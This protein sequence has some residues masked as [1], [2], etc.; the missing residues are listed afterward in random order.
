MNFRTTYILLAVVVAALGFLAWFVFFGPTDK[1][2]ASTEGFVLKAMKAAKIE[3]AQVTAVEIEKAGSDKIVL[4]R[5]DKRWTMAAPAKARVDS[6]AVDDIVAGLL[7][8]K[9]DKS[10]QVADNLGTHGLAEPGVKVTI[11]AGDI[12]ETLNLGNVTTGGERAVVYVTTSDRPNKAQAARRND[13][14]PLF[15]AGA[16][17]TTAAEFVRGVADFR[18]LK[19]VGDGLDSPPN[20]VRGVVVRTDKDKLALTRDLGGRWKFREPADYGDAAEAGAEAFGPK[21]AAGISS[22]GELLNTIVAIQPANR[23]A[24]KPADDLSKFGLAPAQNPLQVD[25][26]RIDGVK[27]TMFIGTVT[28][29]GKETHYA[30]NELDGVV[31]VVPAE[32]VAKLRAALA[33]KGLLRD[34]TVLKLSPARVVAVEIDSAGDKIELHRTAGGWQAFDAEGKARL[35]KSQMVNELLARLAAPQLAASFPPPGVPDERSG[36]A[37]PRIEVRLYEKTLPD[38]KADAATKPK[39]DPASVVKL[40]VGADDVGDVAYARRVA[41]D[42]KSD[43]FLPGEVVQLLARGRL[44]YLDAAMKTFAPDS[45]LKLTFTAGKETVELERPD[46]GKPTAQA[47]WKINSPDRMKGRGADPLKVADL[48][49]QLSFLR[50]IRVAADRVTPDVLNRLEVNPMSPRGKAVVALKGGGDATFL[51]GGDVGTE[52]RTV[53]LK[54]GDQELVFEADRAAFDL[55]QKADVQDAVVHRIDKAKVSAVTL[56]GWNEFNGSPLTVELV[57]KDGAWTAK[58][59]VTFEVDAAKVDAFLNDLTT[60]RAETF[61]VYKDGPKPEH[62]LEVPK[63]ALTAVLTV[64][65][66]EPLTMTI[67]PP[68]KEGKV[69]ATSSRA[70]GDV[71]VTVDRFAAV[72]MKPAALKKD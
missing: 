37:K 40:Q 15:R 36:L 16:E 35:A 58:S 13:I 56:T 34:R 55:L 46:D 25:L 11:R 4:A 32:P 23:D 72:R 63:G 6:Q 51:F 19:I 53:Y 28:A 17:G 3:P 1:S 69:F 26:D 31:A 24:V 5:E 42:G 60:P 66:G 9:L 52:K 8:A 44:A 7:K 70:P 10:A 54:P 38:P 64:D 45:V 62:N 50:P 29:E 65:G 49:N 20:Q 22:V 2:G 59:G 14:A 43:F 47:A 33:N 21:A 12:S 71:F 61:V 41:A 30:R 57:R 48:V 67:S 68:N 39:V 27:E 18:P